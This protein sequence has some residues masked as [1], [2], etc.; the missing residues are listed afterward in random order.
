MLTHFEGA[1][2]APVMHNTVKSHDIF[3]NIVENLVSVFTYNDQRFHS[4]TIYDFY[5]YR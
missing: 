1:S 4:K 3:K 5:Y 2:Y